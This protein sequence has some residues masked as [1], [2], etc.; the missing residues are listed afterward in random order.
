MLILGEQLSI[1]IEQ[2][3]A[4]GAKISI[5]ILDTLI[6]RPFQT[7]ELLG[8]IGGAVDDVLASLELWYM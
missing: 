7:L 6:G 4:C 1:A 5:D 2:N 3:P 8:H